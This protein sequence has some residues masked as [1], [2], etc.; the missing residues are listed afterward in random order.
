[1]KIKIYKLKLNT[2][3]SNSKVGTKELNFYQLVQMFC[4]DT[5]RSKA[6]AELLFKRLLWENKRVSCPLC[7]GTNIAYRENQKR[8]RCYSC[9]DYHFSLKSCTILHSC[10]L[11]IG[12]IL[13]IIL[14]LANNN[15][16][17]AKDIATFAGV[18]ESTA[19]RWRHRIQAAILNAEFDLSQLEQYGL[20]PKIKLNNDCQIDVKEI[21]RTVRLPNERRLVYSDKFK[22]KRAKKKKESLIVMSIRCVKTKR[23]ISFQVNSEDKATANEL[24]LKTVEKGNTIISDAAKAYLG[25]NKLGFKHIAV[26]HKTHFVDKNGNHTNNVE[27]SF[28]KLEALRCDVKH[29][30]EKYFQYYLA[31]SDFHN[32]RVDENIVQKFIDLSKMVATIMPK[33]LRKALIK[34]KKKLKVLRNEM[35]QME[36]LLAA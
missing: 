9:D 27:N 24:V 7:K 2:K 11:P 35:Q 8:W 22:E 3:K 6:M 17:T 32:S 33:N 30:S 25:L 28:S 10:K 14:L 18:A 34:P 16:I 15:K 20:V 26:N 23:T 13:H 5:E 1:M 4:Q 12:K 31:F 19:H 21:V 36:L 29:F